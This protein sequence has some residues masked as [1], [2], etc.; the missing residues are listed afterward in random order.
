MN[1]TKRKRRYGTE[2][3]DTPPV[4]E[5]IARTEFSGAAR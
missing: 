1:D 2:S 4:S 5:I 3:V